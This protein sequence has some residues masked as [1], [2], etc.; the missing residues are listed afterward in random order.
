VS[1]PADR[2]GDAGAVMYDL[3]A[4]LYPICRS[5]TGP[6]VRETLGILG[7][8]VPVKLHEVST[9][10]PVFDWTV[11][12][13]WTIRDAYVADMTGRRVVDFR[14]HNL[15][16]V[17]YSVPVDRTM[18]LAELRPHLF[19]DPAHPSWIP[20][21]TSYYAETW[22]FCLPHDRL[23]AMSEGDYRVVIDSTLEAG[24][25]TYGEIV[26]PGASDDEILISAH[27]CHPSLA[28]DN[29]S[30]V[31]VVTEIA[32]RLRDAPLRHTVRILLIPG[33]IGS[34]TW[35]AL[36]EQR[37]HR[38]RHGLVAVNLG[39]PGAMHY[40][41]SRR[42]DAPVD[43]AAVHV[44]A[45]RR[46]PHTVVDFSPYGYDERQFCSPGIDLPVGC[47]SRTPYAQFPE[48][49]TSADD[50]SLVRPD[51]LRDSLDT[52]LEILAVLDRDRRW[53]NLSPKGE[54]QLGRRGLYD[55]IGGRSDAKSRQ[56]A[57]LWVLN[58]SDGRHGLLDITERS[59]LPFATI[60]DAAD[61]LEKAGLL[62]PAT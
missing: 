60:A 7:E 47:L 26:V 58:L 38:I 4:R 15:H 43:R 13:E 30:G 23:L 50:L 25:L 41:R 11:P 59:G 32:K 21:R 36:N 1:E 48:Y 37:L 51:A 18:T 3:I 5:I 19:T 42:G 9:G 2:G 46:R 53:I 40:K 35:L 39:D 34:I 33:T 55:A 44:L 27:V 29:L 10:T 54:P 20:Y 6:G 14:E 62:A 56:M 17:S 61:D 16:V 24:S 31:A 8:I 57:L 45:R 49:H 22:G 28:N 52:Y 12:K